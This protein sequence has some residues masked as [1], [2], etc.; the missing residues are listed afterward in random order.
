M[1]CHGKIG[2]SGMFFLDSHQ[3]SLDVKSKITMTGTIVGISGKI[4]IVGIYLGIM[5]ALFLKYTSRVFEP[6]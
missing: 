6:R 3:G 1:P 2:T 5:I 4:H